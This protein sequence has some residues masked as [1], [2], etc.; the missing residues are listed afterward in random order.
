MK[1]ILKKKNVLIIFQGTKVTKGQDT[2]QQCLVVGVSK[3]E[4]LKNLSNDER[5]PGILSNGQ[6][7]DVI[8]FP[9]I[10]AISSCPENTVTACYPHANKYRPL[11]GG[12]SI[13]AS[14]LVNVGTLGGFVV[15]NYDEKICLLTCNHVL[16]PIY[17]FQYARPSN[18]VL[19]A[20]SCDVVQP[21]VYDGGKP[22]TDIIAVG[23]RTIAIQFDPNGYNLIDAVIADFTGLNLFSP[24]VLDLPT[25]GSFPFLEKLEY[26]IG[27]TTYKSG[28]TTGLTEATIQSK[29]VDLNVDYYGTIAPFTG[30]IMLYSATRFIAPG[31]SGS[32][33]FVK[34]SGR[35]RMIGLI[36]AASEDGLYGFANH[37][38]DIETL[39]EISEWDG[40]I[41]MTRST[42]D[43]IRANRI[44]YHRT[45]VETLQPVR[46][47]KEAS[48]VSC[49]ACLSKMSKNTLF[50]NV[51]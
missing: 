9:K 35:Y 8:I 4:D 17:N 28:R 33:V 7:T 18:G 45:L 32:P 37:I 6:I 16:G 13:G 41:G 43:Y 15:D 14:G 51:L 2:G 11:Q 10:K 22:V 44:C 27:Q 25:P 46:I 31:D 42:E 19:T 38:Q 1:T 36:F 3:K 29:D 21:G 23:K 39:L 12:I 40:S 50:G 34:S 49:A 47:S 26:S 48:Y 5:I 24:A 20:D 30:Q